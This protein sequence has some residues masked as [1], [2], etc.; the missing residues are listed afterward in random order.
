MDGFWENVSRYP[1]YLLSLIFGIFFFFWTQIKPLFN[2]PAT[3][4]A[5]IAL[6]LGTFA[7]LYFTLEA[8]LG[9]NTV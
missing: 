6:I 2:Q 9:L 8:M 5:I 7:F 4:I 1:R 3:A